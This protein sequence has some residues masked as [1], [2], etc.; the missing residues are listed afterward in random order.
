M[1]EMT[2]QLKK[3]SEDLGKLDSYS[4]G[5]NNYTIPLVLVH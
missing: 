1:Q 3:I 2:V 5:E 4:R